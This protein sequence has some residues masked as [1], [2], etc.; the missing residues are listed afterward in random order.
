MIAGARQRWRGMI[1]HPIL[2]LELRR[3]RRTRWW[4][5]RRFFLFYP[6]LLG[7]VAGYGVIVLLSDSVMKQL[8]VSVTALPMVCLLTAASSLLST[9]LPW[10]APALTASTIVRERELGTLDLLRTTLLTERSIVLGKLGGCLARLWPVILTLILLSPFQLMVV[11]GGGLVSSPALVSVLSMDSV[12]IDVGWPWGWLL[13]AGLVGMLSPWAHLAL[14][15]AVGVFVSVLTRSV[16]TA[17]AVSY[18]AILV[19]RAGLWLLVSVL[20]S[21]PLLLAGLSIDPAG[22]AEA[23]VTGMMLASTLPPLVSVCIEFAGAVFLVWAAI[24]WL[25]RL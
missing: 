18:G 1:D 13:L 9:L 2:Q 22:S 24:W 10:V 11:A 21:L 19:V 25:K 6:A 15:G 20:G 12:T 17:I 8:S 4:P 14:H 23:G 7:C 16:G 5:G 3:I